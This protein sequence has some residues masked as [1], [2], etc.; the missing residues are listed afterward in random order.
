[1]STSLTRMRFSELFGVLAYFEINGSKK[2]QVINIE[3][4]KMF[5]E[6]EIMNLKK[7]S[8]KKFKFITYA[9]LIFCLIASSGA[10]ITNLISSHNFAQLIDMSIY[11]IFSGWIDGFNVSM[12]YSGIYCVAYEKFISAL[13]DLYITVFIFLLIPTCRAIIKRNQKIL[14]LI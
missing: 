9:V 10:C 3:V 4:G 12:S 5:S 8:S 11:D 7:L 13:F 2:R 6:K 1:M 14:Q